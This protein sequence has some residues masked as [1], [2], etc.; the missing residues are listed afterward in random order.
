MHIK[1][2]NKSSMTNVI[3]FEKKY[4]KLDTLVA[5]KQTEFKNIVFA[6]NG[7]FLLCKS[8][9]GYV[10][11]KVNCLR[12]EN[13]ELL[14]ITNTPLVVSYCDPLPNLAVRLLKYSNLSTIKHK[15]NLC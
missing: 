7:I 6:R 11:E 5:N 4:K 9:F 3:I 15:V 12:Y 10:I 2:L 8:N 13:K 14:E 1:T